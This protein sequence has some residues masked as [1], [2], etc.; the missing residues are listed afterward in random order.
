M[1]L[2]MLNLLPSCA[3]VSSSGSS[4]YFGPRATCTEEP[5]SS[6]KEVDTSRQPATREGTSTCAVA[7]YDDS[8]S[9]NGLTL[10]ASLAF[11]LV[12]TAFFTV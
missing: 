11:F 7:A 2:H 1:L 9:S 8:T 10:T 4:N 5:Y 12:V 3:N 6:G